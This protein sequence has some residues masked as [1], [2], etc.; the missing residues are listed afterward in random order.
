MLGFVQELKFCICAW[1]KGLVFSQA[2]NWNHL[3]GIKTEFSLK[4][5]KLHPKLSQ[6]LDRVIS[7][8]DQAKNSIKYE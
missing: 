4:I 2:G 3:A 8:R 5:V 7:A 6:P 1:V